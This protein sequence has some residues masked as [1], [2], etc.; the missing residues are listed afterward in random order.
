[1]TIDSGQRRLYAVCSG[2]A[3]LVVFDLDTH[4]VITS[5]KIGG[6]PDSVALDGTLHRIYCA[7]RSGRLTVIQ[8][9]G[10]NSY[11]VVDEI[12]THYGAHTL[13]VDPILHTVYVAYASLFTNP[14]IAVFSAKVLK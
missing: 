7:G 5:L 8:Q 13:A 10:L 9:D 11:G 1:M 12:R 3:I 6:G 4:R 2:N 14:R